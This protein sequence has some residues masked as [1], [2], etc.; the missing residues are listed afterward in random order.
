MIRY[1]KYQDIDKKKWDK[2]IEE[3]FNE[4][5]YAYS[6]YLDIVCHKWEALVRD[7][8]QSVFPLTTGKKSGIN[9]L[10][11][12]FFTQQLGVFSKNIT[13]KKDVDIF[14]EAIP[15]KYKFVEINLNTFNKNN[16]KTYIST[17]NVTYELHL[18]N[19]YTDNYKNYSYNIKRNIK[20]AKE[21][22]LSIKKNVNPAHIIEIFKKNRGKNIFTLNKKSYQILRS[23]IYDCIN[24]GRADIT[25]VYTSKGDLCAG[26]FFIQSKK[27]VIF[28]FSAT[29][30][31][32]KTTGAMSLLIDSF[33]KE[34]SGR[35]IILDFEGSNNLNLARF[36]NGFGS[37]KNI[38]L[39]IKKNQL[40]YFIKKGVNLAKKIR[41]YYLNYAI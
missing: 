26:A 31:E 7:D 24:R 18:I 32:A 30:K 2:C 8:Y 5:I 35:D 17:P 38:Y 36:Y 15:S 34:N 20:K 4:T 16:S 39:Q 27:K 12:P 33:I 13:E 23:L 3:S 29:N 6:W 41:K 37:E 14:L 1:L 19:S 22:N 9:Y 25:G 40:P 28:L 21:H 11:Q 10:Y